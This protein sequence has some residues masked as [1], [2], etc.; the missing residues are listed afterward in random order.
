M[1]DRFAW[2]VALGL[3]NLANIFD[4]ERFVLGGGLIEAGA[5]LVEP[6]RT[7]IRRTRR[8][9]HP[10]PRDR[11]RGR[12]PGRAGPVPVSSAPRTGAQLAG[13]RPEWFVIEWHR[14][15]AK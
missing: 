8:S 14:N 6:V 12:R 2:W 4:P 9:G 5:L 13:R 10:P 1:I 7:A 15:M 11:H 3:A